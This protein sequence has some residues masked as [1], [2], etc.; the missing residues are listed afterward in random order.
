MEYTTPAN[1]E[2]QDILFAEHG[3]AEEI[4]ACSYECIAI[5][6]RVPNQ[7]SAILA[8]HDFIIAAI[9]R[10][11]G[12]PYGFAYSVYSEGLR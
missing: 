4:F 11:H 3:C 9:E 2:T 5:I 12:G 8:A 6:M 7:L 10:S 1:F